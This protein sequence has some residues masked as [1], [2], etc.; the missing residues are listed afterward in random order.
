MNWLIELKKRNPILYWFGWLTLSGGLICV[1]MT[2]V[3]STE[4]LGISAWIKPMKFFLSIWIFSWTM[5]WILFELHRPK[6]VYRYTIMVVVVMVIELLIITWQAANGRLSHFNVST[7]FYSILFNIMG[8]AIVTL[9]IWTFIIGL[10]FFKLNPADIGSGYLWG[11]RLGIIFFVIFSLEGGM[12][13]ARLAHTVG[14]A[15]G[16]AGLPVMNWSKQY[17]DLR[18]AH[19]FGIHSLQLLPL[20]GFYITRSS[21]AMILLSGVYFAIVTFLLVQ[22]LRG[23]P[24]L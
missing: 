20:F 22:A 17:G 24:L 1:V 11:I 8:V 3:S 16:S 10:R 21:R 9:T 13:A 12:M 7:T 18:V 2:R 15:D 4:V 5:G 23:L 6:A 14:A 19:F